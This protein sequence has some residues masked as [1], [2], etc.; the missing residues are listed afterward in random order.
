MLADAGRAR[1]RKR[2]AVIAPTVSLPKKN[3]MLIAKYTSE[4]VEYFDD[5]KSEIKNGL[6]GLDCRIE[7]VGSTSIP[8]L[9]SKP[10]IDI[11]IV[12]EGESEF[13]NINAGL[14]RLGY[15]HHGNQGI[16]KREVFKRNPHAPNAVLDAIPHHLY[17]CPIDSAALERHL[18][19]RDFLRKHEWAKA[20]Y[21]RLKYALAEQAGQD[22]KIY[23]AL[24]ELHVNAFIDEIVRQEKMDAS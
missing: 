22:R 9:D 3:S 14:L 21:Q 16:E 6:R 11:D 5:L 15:R 8:N 1:L 19:M 20:E 24:K 7:H 10:I 12:Y 13:E 17:V 4:W 23:A 2:T 18:L